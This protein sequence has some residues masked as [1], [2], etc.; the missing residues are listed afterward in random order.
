MSY[1]VTCEDRLAAK[2]TALNLVMVLRDGFD[3]LGSP[4]H[5]LHSSP[6]LRILLKHTPGDPKMKRSINLTVHRFLEKEETLRIEVLVPKT[7]MDLHVL[8]KISTNEH[9]FN[10]CQLGNKFY[11]LSSFSFYIN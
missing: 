10:V 6:V 5:C 7:L 2:P 3:R 9:R 1:V 11:P 8:V 4:S